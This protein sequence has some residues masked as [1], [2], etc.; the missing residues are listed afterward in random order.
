M[1]FS[2]ALYFSVIFIDKLKFLLTRIHSVQYTNFQVHLYT[3]ES[4]P[5]YEFYT[6]I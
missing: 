6:G 1:V 4:H 2:V 5:I 3:S